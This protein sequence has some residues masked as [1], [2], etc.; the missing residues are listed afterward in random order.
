MSSTTA[1]ILGISMRKSV[2][3]LLVLI[4]L[5]SICTMVAKAVSGTSVVADSWVPK[6]PMKVPRANLGVAVVN[7]NIYAIG[8]N[9][10]AGEYNF[11]QGFYAGITG[12]TVNTN[13][14]YNPVTDTWASKASMPTP[15][16]SFAIAVYQNKIYCIGGRTSIPLFNSQTFT[17]ITQVYDPETDTWQTKTPLPKIEWPLQAGVVDGKIYVIGR[18]GATYAYDPTKDSWTTKANSPSVNTNPIS[19]FVAAV[20][21]N[22]IYVIGI[23]GLN[24]IYDPLTDAWSSTHSSQPFSVEGLLGFGT[25]QAAIGTTTGMLAPERIYVF[26]ENRTYIYDASNDTWASGASMSK[27]RVNFGAAVINDTFYV[28]GGGNN[29]KGFAASYAPSA[30]NE[31]YFPVGYGTPDPSYVLEHVPPKISFLSPLNQTYNNSSVSITFSVDKPVNWVGYSLDGAQNLTVIDNNTLTNSTVTSITITNMINGQH[32]L[33]IYANDTYGN[34]GVSENV[35]F[36]VKIPEFFEPF[37]MA[38]VEVALVIFI[39]M[40]VVC[41]LTYFKKRS[42]RDS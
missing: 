33:V 7:G 19:G 42:N 26:F 9:T 13:E 36:S 16:D 11:N 24:L 31:Q 25:F 6:E 39:I 5:T 10:V 12:G 4:L 8:G 23:S 35:T 18:S 32:H 2:T 27:E 38:I 41:L 17:A 40:A 34:V 29:P 15:R 22:K 3:L 28:I 37:T 30:A 21:D 1:H 14:Q 20:F